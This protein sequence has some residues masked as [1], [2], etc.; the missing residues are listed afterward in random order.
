MPVFILGRAETTRNRLFFSFAR[1]M[2]LGN[3]SVGQPEHVGHFWLP[4]FQD[5]TPW[6]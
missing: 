5:L 6:Y 2:L 1:L 4:N 3:V